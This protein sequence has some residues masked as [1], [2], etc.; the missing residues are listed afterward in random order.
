MLRGFTGPLPS[1]VPVPIIQV[2]SIESLHQLH[3]P[4]VYNATHRSESRCCVTN[5][6]CPPYSCC[7]E[8]SRC[9]RFLIGA[10]MEAPLLLFIKSSFVIQQFILVIWGCKIISHPVGLG[11]VLHLVTDKCASS[12]RGCCAVPAPIM[13]AGN[14]P[15][16]T[17]SYQEIPSWS[18]SS[19]F[20]QRFE[21][22]ILPNSLTRNHCIS[23]LNF[24]ISQTSDCLSC[25]NLQSCV[26]AEIVRCEISRAQWARLYRSLRYKEVEE[27][28]QRCDLLVLKFAQRS[29]GI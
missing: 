17:N 4:S 12:V 28:C 21:F 16:W 1:G 19:C 6:L 18:A 7:N 5:R 2:D 27:I 23:A 24:L 20:S 25:S 8:R 13:Q 11:H 15:W 10:S 3:H 26:W 9:C 22:L 14:L 29:S